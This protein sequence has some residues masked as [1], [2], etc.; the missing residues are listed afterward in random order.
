MFFNHYVITFLRYS[1]IT[2]CYCLELHT[3]VFDDE[4]VR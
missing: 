3:Q 1:S 2:D 4:F